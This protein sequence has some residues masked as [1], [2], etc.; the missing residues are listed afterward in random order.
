MWGVGIASERKMRIQA[1]ELV[2]DNLQAELVPFSFLH[3]DGGEVIHDAPCA[4]IP[5]LWQ[6]IKDL[7]DHDDSRG[8]AN[9]VN[10]ID[11]LMQPYIS[12]HRVTWHKGAIPEE[13]VWL[14]LGG[15]KGGGTFK[16]CFQ[17][18]NVPSPNAPENTC[19]FSIFEAPDTYCN[20]KISLTRHMEEITD[21]EN[22]AWRYSGHVAPI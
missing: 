14:K 5:H 12:V 19:V 13:E 8:Y 6:K 22:Q 3:K 11:C 10:N 21:L 16:A 15:D 18:L 20:L 17:H 9:N 1:T 7:L 4:Y 2:G